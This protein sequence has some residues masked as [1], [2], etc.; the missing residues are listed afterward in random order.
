MSDAAAFDA[1]VRRHAGDAFRFAY[2]LARDEGVAQDVV[3]EAYLRAWRSRSDLRDERAA[4]AWLFTIIRR[5]HAR[6]HERKLPPIDAIDDLV[7]EDEETPSALD[8]TEV[9]QLRDAIGRIDAKYREPLLLQIVGGFSCE[10]IAGQLGLTAQAVMTQV[11]RAR[12]KLKALLRGE[13]QG[14]VHELY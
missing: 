5:E 6:L 8:L 3:Q 4:K 9:Q 12:A 14:K 13:P 2:W 11:F 7:I 1:F 10:E